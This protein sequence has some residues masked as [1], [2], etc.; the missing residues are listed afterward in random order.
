MHPKEA[1][2][3]LKKTRMRMKQKKE[4]KK[5]PITAI[6]IPMAATI[7]IAMIIIT[8]NGSINN[9]SNNNNDKKYDSKQ[10]KINKIAPATDETQTVFIIITV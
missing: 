3:H 9:N 5:M 4:T 10:Y 1:S 8:I 7:M 6:T 2:N